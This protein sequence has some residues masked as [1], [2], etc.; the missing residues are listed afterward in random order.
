MAIH[1]FNWADESTWPF[2]GPYYVFVAAALNVVGK[3]L[4]PDWTGDELSSRYNI[5]QQL[6]SLS[7]N[8]PEQVN[9]RYDAVWLLK[10]F[11]SR[12]VKAD[13]LAEQDWQE[14]REAYAD[15][16]QAGR[17]ARSR[18]GEVARA[19]R[20]R[21]ATGVIVGAIK[22]EDGDFSEFAKER[23]QRD[24]ALSWIVS[25]EVVRGDVFPSPLGSS[26]TTSYLFFKRD[27]LDPLRAK[28]NDVKVLGYLSPYMQLMLDV[29]R[30]CKI[31]AEHQ[32]KIDDAIQPFIDS[33]WKKRGLPESDKL[34]TA[35][36]TMVR[37]PAAQAGRAKKKAD[38]RGQ[39]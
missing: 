23:W 11:R 35:M 24:E 19:I 14:A 15:Y 32:S 1:K 30:E 13:E 36:A 39:P 20:T 9:R 5:G 38:A 37:E 4:F 34:R 26:R 33:E 18:I 27:S 6:Q 17:V 10:K 28:A 12:E 8:L 22:Y 29:V 2:S 7:E 21:A 25:G 3:E 31:D 16:E